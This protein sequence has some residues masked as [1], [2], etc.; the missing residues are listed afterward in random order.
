M[1]ATAIGTPLLVFGSI[2]AVIALAPARISIGLVVVGVLGIVVSVKERADRPQGRAVSPSE[3]PELHAIVDRLCVVADLPKPEIVIEPERQPNSWL[4]ALS[5]GRARLHV[6]RGLLE[7]TTPHE[8]EAV[9]GHELSH[10]A[11]RDAVVMTV[12]GGPGAALMAGGTRA[13]HFGWWGIV[14]GAV[15]AAIGWLSRVGTQALSR[16]RELAADAGSAALTGRPAALASALRKVAGDLQ[17]M[18]RRDL[19]EAAARDAF[20]LMPAG[21]EPQEWLQRLTATHPSLAE[22]IERLEHLEQKLH[23]ARLTAPRD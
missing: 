17:R 2:A 11:N 13:R 23:A 5:R 21:E 10:L 1:V 7:I 12:V 19:R 15:A 3:A 4:V 22:R 14:A 8:L 18:P 16:H 20:H 6:T 9:V